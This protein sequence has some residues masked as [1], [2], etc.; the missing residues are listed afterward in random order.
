MYL[1]WNKDI[2]MGRFI[3]GIIRGILCYAGFGCTVEMDI[4]EDKDTLKCGFIVLFNL[5][6]LLR[7]K[8]L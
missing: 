5:D 3:A 1:R 2:H 4:V 6:V 8:T 7:E